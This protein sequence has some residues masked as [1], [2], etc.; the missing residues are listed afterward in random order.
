LLTARGVPKIAD[1]GLVQ[2]LADVD[3]SREEP[4]PIVGTPAYMAPE[5]ATGRT[6]AIGPASDIHALGVILYELL[7]GRTPFRGASVGET[8]RQVVEMVPDPPSR[9][10]PELPR[11]LDAICMR[12]LRKDP[13]RRYPNAQEL[14]DD[15]SRFLDDTGSARGWIERFRP[16]FPGRHRACV[17]RHRESERA[18]EE[19]ETA[20]NETE[21]AL[22]LSR[23]ALA[24]Y[25]LARGDLEAAKAVLLECDPRRGRPDRRDLKWSDLWNRCRTEGLRGSG[26]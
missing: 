11:A 18:R 9:L 14:A 2:F 6:S 19:A 17:M 25:Q 10:R 3:S 8:L 7:V 5:Q 26:V 24:E 20:L 15:L 13:L 12:C 23:V 21:Q 1:F 16:R 4:G 22:Y